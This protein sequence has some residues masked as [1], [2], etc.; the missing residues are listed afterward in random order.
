MK[1]HTRARPPRRR[2]SRRVWRQPAG[3]FRGTRAA[4]TAATAPE[5]ELALGADVEEASLEAEADAQAGEEQR[6][7]LD[8]GRDAPVLGAQRAFEQGADRQRTAAPESIDLP[9]SSALVRMI[10]TA[11]A[12]RAR[13]IATQ[14]Q[15][16]RRPELRHGAAQREPPI[17]RCRGQAVG[18]AARRVSCFAGAGCALRRGRPWP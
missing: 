10:T 15:G 1:P 4:A 11:P 8:Q 17:R 6:R 9:G 5:Q 18:V 16:E 3:A 13:T 7:G 12:T 14:R 2:R